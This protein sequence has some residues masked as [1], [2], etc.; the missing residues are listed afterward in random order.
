MSD[1]TH[2][3]QYVRCPVCGAPPHERCITPQGSM[4]AVPHAERTAEARRW[5]AAQ[6]DGA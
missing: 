1:L 2:L 5:A 3:S 6:D 4:T